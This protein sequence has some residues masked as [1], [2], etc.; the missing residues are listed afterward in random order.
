MAV[1][2]FILILR[3]MMMSSA[4]AATFNAS[5]KMNW[6]EWL[7]MPHNPNDYIDIYFIGSQS[8]LPNRRVAHIHPVFIKAHAVNVE[9]G[10]FYHRQQIDEIIAKHNPEYRDVK[11]P[12]RKGSRI[13]DGVNIFRIRTG[14]TIYKVNGK[15]Y[16][17]NEV[18]QIMP[19][20]TRQRI[21]DRF[22]TL[23]CLKRNDIYI[24]HKVARSIIRSRARKTIDKFIIKAVQR[25]RA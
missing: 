9:T 19:D 23:D 5:D 1:L 2:N 20:V 12:I 21:L 6:K 4:L 17:L 16:Y 14:I 18:T 24:L 11:I 7:K 3:Y 25:I 22:G 13:V 10:M 8:Y 15:N